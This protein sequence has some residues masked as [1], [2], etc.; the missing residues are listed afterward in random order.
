LA[1]RLD[2][3]SI[4]RYQLLVRATDGGHLFDH[5]LLELLITDDNDNWP[6]MMQNNY[7]I[8][9]FP[10][11]YNASLVPEFPVRTSLF[12]KA[13]DADLPENSH[14]VYRIFHP[15]SHANRA[16]ESLSQTFT[17]DPQSGQLIVQ[18]AITRA[19]LDEWQLFVEACD[20]LNTGLS[21]T[22]CSSPAK[23]HIRLAAREPPNLPRIH[24]T[25][26]SV[27]EDDRVSDRE[28]AL[29]QVQPTNL[30]G[31]WMLTS[32][33]VLHTGQHVSAFRLD[34]HTGRVFTT[35]PLDYEVASAYRL[36]VQFRLANFKPVVLAHT[37]FVVQLV[38]VN[39]CTPHLDSPIFEIPP[40]GQFWL[41]VQIGLFHA[42][43]SCTT[44]T[45]VAHKK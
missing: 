24:C 9:L 27:L 41:A 43:V 19:D 2:R 40:G 18:H 31:D 10:H 5:L 29:C 28:V 26:G 30:T 11:E 23:V 6:V 36:R 20:S 3:E 14:L 13:T 17:V 42:V 38:D 21:S 4:D 16:T 35:R 8:T 25:A 44:L 7:E 1:S 37:E 39:D 32:V 33:T 22:H 34:R 12:V 15:P 45:F